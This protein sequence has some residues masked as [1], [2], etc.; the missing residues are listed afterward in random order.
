MRPSVSP[1]GGSALYAITQLIKPCQCIAML[2][3]ILRS[4]HQGY[5]VNL[6]HKISIRGKLC[7]CIKHVI[8]RRTIYLVMNKRLSD[9]DYTQKNDNMDWFYLFAPT[10][11]ERN[12][13]KSYLSTVLFISVLC[14]L[15]FCSIIYIA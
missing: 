14:R 12:N 11:S 9:H 1:L 8:A 6:P 4:A 10:V 15:H 7:R 3:D 2:A 5:I 13:E